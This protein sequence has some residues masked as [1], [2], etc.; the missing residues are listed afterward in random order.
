MPILEMAEA[1]RVGHALT[2]HTTDLEV[3]VWTRLQVDWDTDEMQGP[4][5]AAL[6]IRRITQTLSALPDVPVEIVIGEDYGLTMRTGQGEYEMLAQDASDF[7]TRPDVEGATLDAAP[8]E[9]GLKK[10]EPF[11]EDDPLRPA[12]EGVL[13]EL[14]NGHPRA[15]ATDGHR[16]SRIGLDVDGGAE[17]VIVPKKAVSLMRRVMEEEATLEIGDG[18]VALDAGTTTVYS[19]TIDE[20]YPNHESVVPRNDKSLRVSRNELLSAVERVGLYSS[21]A[22]H[23]IR[24][25]I[26]PDRLRLEGEDIERSAE[27]EEEVACDYDSEPMEIGFNSNYLEDVLQAAEGEEVEMRLG[28][29]T[30]A[31]TVHPD[32]TE[33]HLMLL[34]PVMLNE[35]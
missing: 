31:A 21:S 1:R 35:H 15:V 5:A 17:D 13:L 11:T 26:T 4:E 27:A 18:H 22:T 29:P 20:T 28:G 34:M 33:D 7:P 6:P 2:L 9:E 23:Q 12:M 24:L 8:L 3:H 10:T 30:D 19:K 32:G 16:L 25:S 14:A